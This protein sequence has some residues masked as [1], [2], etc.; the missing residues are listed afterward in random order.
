MPGAN[1][2]TGSP[3]AAGVSPT[4]DIKKSDFVRNVKD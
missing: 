1:G 4:R 3:F 2:I